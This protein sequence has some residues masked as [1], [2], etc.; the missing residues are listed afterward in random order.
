MGTSTDQS[1]PGSDMHQK[2]ANLAYAYLKFTLMSNVSN[3]GTWDT[4]PWASQPWGAYQTQV[5]MGLGW[6]PLRLGT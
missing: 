5:Q 2:V 1:K 6:L 4:Q 3:I